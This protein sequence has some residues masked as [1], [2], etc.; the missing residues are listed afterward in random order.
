VAPLIEFYKPETNTTAEWDENSFLQPWQQLYR[1]DDDDAEPFKFKVILP[2]QEINSRLASQFDF[3]ISIFQLSEES[4]R[5][6]HDYNLGRGV[7]GSNGH[8]IR[9]TI[10]A[11]EMATYSPAEASDAENVEHAS[12]D[13]SNR[14]DKGSYIDSNDFDA[15]MSIQFSP[16]EKKLG[17]RGVGNWTDFA[18]YDAS[19]AGVIKRWSAEANASYM[20]AGGAAIVEVESKRG[21]VRSQADWIFISSHGHHSAGEGYA[22]GVLETSVLGE[23]NVRET[24]AP[25][26]VN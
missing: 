12:F 9:C 16:S 5:I 11:S 14:P 15:K 7:V 1:F 26:D 10:Q 4:T 18:T 21:L 20:K 6:R 22:S 23:N 8:E 19:A 17:A 3:K 24:V 2:N 13:W 25:E